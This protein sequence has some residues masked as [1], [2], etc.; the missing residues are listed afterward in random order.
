VL[1]VAGREVLPLREQFDPARSHRCVTA[2]HHDTT[3][4]PYCGR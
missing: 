4:R 3:N 1:E 2:V